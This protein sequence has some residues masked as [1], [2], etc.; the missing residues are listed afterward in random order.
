MQS[1]DARG[2]HHVRFLFPSEVQTEY[3]RGA[4]ATFAKIVAA[5]LGGRVVGINSPQWEH[6]RVAP[7]KP[8]YYANP[9]HYVAEVMLEGRALFVDVTGVYA[10]RGAMINCWRT[11]IERDYNKGRSIEMYL[12]AE[13][14]IPPTYGA[15]RWLEYPRMIRRGDLSRGPFAVRFV[16]PGQDQMNPLAFAVALLLRVGGAVVQA[17]DPENEDGAE[18]ASARREMPLCALSVRGALVT[19][20]GIFGKARDFARFAGDGREL[21]L[22]R[23]RDPAAEITSEELSRA[24]AVADTIGDELLG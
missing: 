8:A 23:V 19:F 9:L 14:W 17:A 3:T 22:R 13:R 2:A 12:T 20:L 6:I 18:D 7:N 11:F 21:A 5:R 24:R 1:R 10:S 15:S 4:C 16:Y